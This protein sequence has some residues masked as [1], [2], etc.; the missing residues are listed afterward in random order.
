[1]R[2]TE[3]ILSN[4]NC[5]KYTG[6]TGFAGNFTP[7]E[8]KKIEKCWSAVPKL[9]DLEFEEIRYESAKEHEDWKEASDAMREIIKIKQKRGLYDIKPKENF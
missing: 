3:I 7:E 6:F 5:E 4:S 8:S 2:L 9:D 1:M